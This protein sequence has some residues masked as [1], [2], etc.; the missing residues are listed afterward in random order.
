MGKQGLENANQFKKPG[1][2]NN[3]SML[4]GGN[5]PIN[6][7]DHLLSSVSLTSKDY[8]NFPALNSST[9]TRLESEALEKPP[10]RG[11]SPNLGTGSRVPAKISGRPTLE[12][13]RQQAHSK[14]NS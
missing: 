6:M 1:K 12:S 5:G 13:S 7:R 14:T 3:V 11:K 8:R 2:S 10:V 9:K 4:Y